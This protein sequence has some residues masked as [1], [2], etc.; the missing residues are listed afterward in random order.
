MARILAISNQKGG[1]GKT[2]TSINLAAALAKAGRRVLL[3]DLDPQ[4]NASSGLGYPRSACTMG[5]YDAL[6]GFRE[7]SS[8][9]LPTSIDTLEIVPATRDL[10]GAEIELVD[11]PG[12][13]RCLRRALDTVRDD[14]DFIVIDC[15]PSLS[16]LTVNALTSA[17]SVLIPLQVEY[18]AMEGL[19]ELLRTIGAVRKGL[20]PDL[21]REGIL[22]TMVDSRNRLSRDVMEQT[23]EVF[24]AEV[25]DTV[26][27]RNVRLGEAPSHGKS[28]IEYDP[29]STGARAYS[30]LALELLGRLVARSDRR[31]RAAS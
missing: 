28:I 22:L 27:P 26:I 29:R 7:L 2:T 18:Y 6:M 11:E 15:P 9:R 16:L 17:D 25:F 12:R 20:N 19:G 14:F 13:E 4:G 1:V 8:L 3:V 31:S 23:R 21:V 10:V 24:G 5:I 30:S